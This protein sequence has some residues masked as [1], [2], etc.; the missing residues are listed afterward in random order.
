M[1]LLN[2]VNW[3][4]ATVFRDIQMDFRKYLSMIFGFKSINNNGSEVKN[5]FNCLKKMYQ[6]SIPFPHQKWKE[7]SEYKKMNHTVYRKKKAKLEQ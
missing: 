2:S 6:N 7:Q 3:S 1:L 5:V 4:N